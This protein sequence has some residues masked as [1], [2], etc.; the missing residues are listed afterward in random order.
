MKNEKKQFLLRQMGSASEAC[1]QQ[2]VAQMSQNT[3]GLVEDDAWYL[4]IVGIKPEHQGQGL[5]PGLITEV[6][7]QSDRLQLQTY[8]E[9]FSARNMPFYHRLGYAT[10]RSFFEPTTQC[11]YWLM[12]RN[13]PD[14]SAEHS[15]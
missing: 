10:V 2:I 12:V 7:Q 5:G 9:T 1:Y 6:L 11:E 3:A 14:K 13:C 8:L 4:S 15:T